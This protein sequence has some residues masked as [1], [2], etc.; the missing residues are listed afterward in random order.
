MA[1]IDDDPMGDYVRGTTQPNL[2]DAEDPMM[3]GPRPATKTTST[4]WLQLP[5]KETVGKVAEESAHSFGVGVRDVVQG[6]IGGLADL[7][8]SPFRGAI[9]YV[10]PGAAIPPSEMID[11]LGANLPPWLYSQPSSAREKMLSPVVQAGASMIPVGPPGTSA[12][13]KTLVAPTGNTSLPRAG[14]AVTSA[15]AGGAAGEAA[16]EAIPENSPWSVLKPLAQL[17]GNIVGAGL[18]NVTLSGAERLV[19]AGIGKLNA[20][21]QAYNELGMKPPTVGTVT[22]SP[23]IQN[24]EMTASQVPGGMG[25]LRGKMQAT[26]DKFGNVVDDAASSLHYEATGRPGVPNVSQTGEVVQQKIRNWRW[27]ADD[28]NSF[29]SQE[30][31]KFTPVDSRMGH[32]TLDLSGYKSAL[33]AGAADSELAGL[34]ATQKALARQQLQKLLDAIETDRPGSSTV[35]WEQAQA[36]RRRI[37]DMRGT[38]EFQQG[39]GDAALTKIYAGLSGDMERAANNNGVGRLWKEANEYATEGYNFISRVADKAVKTNN[40]N[41][42]I[43]PAK[44]A[45]DLLSSYGDDLAQLRRHVPEAADALASHQLKQMS[46]AK[47]GQALAPGETSAN[48][49]LTNLIKMKTEDPRAY[50]ALFGHNPAIARIIENLGTVA[51]SLR[52]SGQLANVSK[53]AP[54]AYLLSLLGGM[55]GGAGGQLL[56]GDPLTAAATATMGAG[57]PFAGGK[58]FTNPALIRALSGQSGPRNVRPLVTGVLGAIPGVTADEQRRQ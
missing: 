39:I 53:T 47:P 3:P 18:S 43:A 58:V 54:A 40:P 26:L 36:L 17:G 27:N 12:V 20:T 1:G 33:R 35:R 34:D 29:V 30:K 57:I 8:T 48:T 7:V 10:S 24:V 31:A 42:D 2:G 25:P 37:G 14:A 46:A 9:N 23:G 16:K 4:S 15:L 49:F 44:A 52:Q 56:T 50:E 21:A 55:A 5:S 6:R 22:G 38:P 51:G 32:A 13:N 45:E 28:P 11:R 41:Q 19:N